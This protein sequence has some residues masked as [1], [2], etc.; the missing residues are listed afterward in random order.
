MDTTQEILLIILASFLAI[1]LLLSIVLVIK[2]LQVI[3]AL[4]HILEKAE[5]VADKADVV[6]EFFSRAA[7]PMA[8]SRLFA[9][10]ADVVM[11]RKSK[12][13]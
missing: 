3:S 10:I 8:I 12:K 5:H 7:A 11:E 13:K 4:K 2:I 6:T 1:F 9:G